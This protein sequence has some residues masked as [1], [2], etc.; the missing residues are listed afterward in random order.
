M[1]TNL[2][3]ALS[4]AGL[5][6][7]TACANAQVANFTITVKITRP[8]NGYK[9]FLQYVKAG[10]NQPSID[11]AAYVNGQ[12]E[13]KGKT[14]NPQK[15]FLYVEK[16][17]NGFKPSYIQKPISVYLEKGNIVVTT[18]NAILIYN[19]EVVKE[20]TFSGT[21]LNDDYQGYW[22]ILNV[23][24]PRLDSL[25]DLFRKAYQDKNSAELDK[26]NPAFKQM[27]AETQKAEEDYFYKHLNSLVSLDWLKQSF[28]IA[29]NK[30]KVVAMF[31]KMSPAV[32]KSVDGKAYSDLLTATSSVEIGGI[33]PDFSA[34]NI[35]GEHVTLSS[36]RG[37]YVLLDFWA[38]WCAP[39]RKENP[40]VLK[41]YNNFKGKNFTVVSFSMD[42]SKKSWE[43]AVEK[44]A[45]PWSQ[46]SDLLAWQGPVSHLYGINGIPAN[47]LIDPQGKIIAK[48]L[49][50]D[51]LD[52]ELSKILK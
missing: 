16:G 41:A 21:P 24:K 12:F 22:N 18:T 37:K 6:L 4:F 28:N 14:Q 8:I 5:C 23:F 45:L 1:N 48:D 2:K 35:K 36:Y 52:A 29:Q 47:F 3:A 30:S 51:A 27:E 43:N 26:I 50:G 11:S 40:N 32:K 7:I 20:A 9:A 31:S 38:S 15:A 34:K 42:E 46:I 25:R 10:E 19:K 49:R 33:A 39:C 44:D 17:N 13:I